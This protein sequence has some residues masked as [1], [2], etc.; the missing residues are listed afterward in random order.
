MDN[1]DGASQIPR[2]T[3]CYIIQHLP[4]EP[5]ELVVYNSLI[6]IYQNISAPEPRLQIL[7]VRFIIPEYLYPLSTA[8]VIWSLQALQYQQTLLDV[9][10]APSLDNV[11]AFTSVG[12]SQ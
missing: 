7:V 10:P 5:P 1:F 3:I 6:T 9:C 2:R 8:T 12:I 4:P 11:V